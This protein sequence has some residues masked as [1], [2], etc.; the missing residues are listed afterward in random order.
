[1]TVNYVQPIY[2]VQLSYYVQV[3]IISLDI[4]CIDS[5]QRRCPQ[6]DYVTLDTC[7]DLSYYFV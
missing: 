2:N 1:M 3:L 7:S 4:T 5:M 6:Y